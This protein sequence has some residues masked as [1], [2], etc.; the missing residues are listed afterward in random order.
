MKRIISLALAILGTVA[1]LYAQS[2]ADPT[3]VI[4]YQMEGSTD[5][6]LHEC[7]LSAGH[8][9]AP[10]TLAEA[11]ARHLTA[12]LLCHPDAADAAERQEQVA[13]VERSKVE[14]A[15]RRAD[16][17]ATLGKQAAQVATQ[18]A[19]PIFITSADSSNFALGLFLQ[20]YGRNVTVARRRSEGVA[21]VQLFPGPTITATVQAG[22]LHGALVR[23]AADDT[24]KAQH[25][26]L[27]QIAA[28]INEWVKANKVALVTRLLVGPEPPPAPP[29]FQTGDVATSHLTGYRVT[30]RGTNSASLTF[31]TLDGTTQQVSDAALPWTQDVSVTGGFFAYVSAQNRDR[32]GGCVMVEILVSGSVVKSAESCGAFVIATASGRFQ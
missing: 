22:D 16:R 26:A 23:K 19:V 20:P 29:L 27:R 2:D 31:S 30:G 8:A 5:Y 11:K 7:P 13:Y 17:I 9:I 1:A 12:C 32:D 14:A 21:D 6:H 18:T 28:D 24:L 4:V 25:D 3:R 15:Q 10:I